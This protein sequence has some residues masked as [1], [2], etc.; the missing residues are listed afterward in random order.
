MAQVKASGDEE[1]VTPMQDALGE[2][3][4]NAVGALTTL[5]ASLTRATSIITGQD[6]DMD[7]SGPSMNGMSSPMDAMGSDPRGSMGNDKAI[8]NID[9]AGDESERPMK[10]E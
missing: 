3:L 6:G 7:D 2:P 1:I 8:D 4:N 10:E 9:I 5:K